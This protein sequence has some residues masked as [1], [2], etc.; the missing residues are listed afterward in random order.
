MSEFD[1]SDGEMDEDWTDTRWA[2]P[3][4]TDTSKK[5]DEGTIIT[6]CHQ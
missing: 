4:M 1:V 6:V 5:D 3:D 2:V